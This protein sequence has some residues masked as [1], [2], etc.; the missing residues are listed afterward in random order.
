MNRLWTILEA[1]SPY[2]YKRERHP[3]MK[4]ISDVKDSNLSDSIQWL[5]LEQWNSSGLKQRG[6]L[7]NETMFAFTHTLKSM[8]EITQYLLTREKNIFICVF[9]KFTTAPL[10]R[11]FGQYRTYAR[12]NYHVTVQNLLE[13]EKTLKLKVSSS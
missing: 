10:E 9:G 2:L 3:F 5:E 7:T 4:P 13:G 6:V 8:K 1:K 11:R 12:S